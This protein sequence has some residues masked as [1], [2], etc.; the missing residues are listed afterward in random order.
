MPAKH[1]GCQLS[2][3]DAA[4][5]GAAG[6]RQETP[7]PGKT[8]PIRRAR[9]ETT[10]PSDF[11]LDM[12]NR[13]HY[14][15]GRGGWTMSVREGNGRSGRGK[16]KPASEAIR[17][18]TL[19]RLQARGEHLLR[20]FPEV[21]KTLLRE[22]EGGL[23]AIFEQISTLGGQVSRRAQAT[24]RDLEARAERLLADLESQAA[25]GLRPLLE[26]ANVPSQTAMESLDGR[27]VHLET[28]IGTLVDERTTL[29]GRVDELTRTLA[30]ERA[31]FRTR[32]DDVGRSVADEGATVRT[33]VEEIG[34]TL[35]EMRAD[36]SER[37]RDLQLRLSIAEEVRSELTALREQLDVLSRG[38][39]ARTL[40]IGKLDDRLVRVETRLG[41]VL[42]EHAAR[43]VD[44]EDVRRRLIGV[45]RAG[46][47]ASQLVRAAG[48]Q[49]AQAT[50][51]GR[52]HAARLGA[53]AEE[54]ATARGEAALL[55]G[56]S[57]ETD[58]ERRQLELR[59]GDLL[60]R[61]AALRDEVIGLVARLSDLEL[62]AVRRPGVGGTGDRAEG[63]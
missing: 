18:T 43:T 23:D 5:P 62:A 50:A 30:D 33:R 38:Q 36:A 15:K 8:I 2:E 22:G 35:E 61:Q 40:D 47:E 48:D 25:R 44:H 7:P 20:W 11:V 59:L 56:R 12:R 19:R 1:G 49:A 31:A 39:A 55:N 45:E 17:E 28:R 24:G 58:R 9:A 13:R 10:S 57:N 26:R 34:S 16:A 41:D 14:E 29:L 6:G 46:E 3:R 54:L 53:L 60:E 32:V 51:L 37:V 21:R 63:H 42:K 52:Q 4:E 27:V